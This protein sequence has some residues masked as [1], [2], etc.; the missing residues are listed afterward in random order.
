LTAEAEAA[1][2]ARRGDI[3]LAIE[4]ESGPAPQPVRELNA[5]LEWTSFTVSAPCELL[6]DLATIRAPG[7]IPHLLDRLEKRTLIWCWRETRVDECTAA[8][9]AAG[10]QAPR[11]AG[12]TGAG[13]PSPPI[14][15]TGRECL[16]TSAELLRNSHSQVARFFYLGV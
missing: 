3:L 4:T 5:W 13:E 11:P 8:D 12:S 14:A 16:R 7:V 9:Y 1:A 10:A 6:F 2:D 15:S